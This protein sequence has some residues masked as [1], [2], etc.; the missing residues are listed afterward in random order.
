MFALENMSLV[1]KQ[2]DSKQ[3]FQ[4]IVYIAH[5]GKKKKKTTF[6]SAC[7]FFPCSSLNNQWT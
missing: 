4:T 1:N 6:G 3:L 5:G 2:V 7:S